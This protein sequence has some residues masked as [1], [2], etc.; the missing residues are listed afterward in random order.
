[1]IYAILN[2]KMLVILAIII[3]AGFAIYFYQ[4][5]YKKAEEK[6]QQ[7]EQIINNNSSSLKTYRNEEWGFEFQYSQ[8]WIF[9]ENIFRSYY[10]KFNLELFVPIGEKRDESF[11]VNIVLPEFI[12]GFN[13]LEKTTSEVIVDGVKGIK[14]QYDFEG[15]PHISIILPLRDL[16]IILATGDGSKQ[17]LDEFNQILA[18]FKFLK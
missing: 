8:S 17:Y 10:S 13:G 3:L 7:S 12:R 5:Q 14:Y 4:Y 9:E 18:T 11:L 1:M 16:R 2:K 6:P 15:S